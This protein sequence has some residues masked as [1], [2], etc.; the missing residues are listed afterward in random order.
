[1][2]T[3][4]YVKAKPISQEI[5]KSLSTSQYSMYEIVDVRISPLTKMPSFFVLQDLF[6]KTLHELKDPSFASQVHFSSGIV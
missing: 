5:V 6:T 4:I 2:A 3:T 1:M